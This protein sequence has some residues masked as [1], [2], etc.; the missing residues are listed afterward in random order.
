LDTSG[1]VESLQ[2]DQNPNKFGMGQ[3]LIANH[4]F[5]NVGEII[6][7]NKDENGLT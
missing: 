3:K 2:H 4:F 5:K 7:N 1:A 6:N